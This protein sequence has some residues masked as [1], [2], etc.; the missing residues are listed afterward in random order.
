[1]KRKA[2]NRVILVS[3]M[4]LLLGTLLLGCVKPDPP[5][6][7]EELK[8]TLEVSTT[9][10]GVLPYGSEFTL[11]WATTNTRTLLINNKQHYPIDAGSLKIRLFKDTIFEVR[12]LNI[13]LSAKFD[14]EV[15]VGDWT[16]SKLGLLTHGTWYLTSIKF[17]QDN[18]PLLDV[19]LTEID[20][21]DQY[22]YSV[23]G[24][25]S[26]YRSGVR[27]GYM[28]WVFS[29]DEDSII[30]AP[31]TQGPSTY[32]IDLLDDKKLTISTES[33]DADG[34]PYVGKASYER[35]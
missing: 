26:V 35:K 28:D 13:V 6:G 24:K 18:I 16:T 10:A 4:I 19:I 27:I 11:S 31:N 8:P 33:I 5:V 1:M 20:K 9:P 21:T 30:Y 32:R 17:Y 22:L 25:H 34:L 2:K 7:P 12:A 29:S 15:K 14:K 3:I 23:D